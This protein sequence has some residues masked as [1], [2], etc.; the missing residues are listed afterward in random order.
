MHQSEDIVRDSL[1]LT[2]RAA[3]SRSL[4]L[5]ALVFCSTFGCS[6]D[7]PGLDRWQISDP[8]LPES[9][10]AAIAREY[11]QGLTSHD[12]RQRDISAAPCA[13]SSRTWSFADETVEVS[14]VYSFYDMD[15]NCSEGRRSWVGKFSWR[16]DGTLELEFDDH[17]DVWQPGYVES[18]FPRREYIDSVWRVSASQEPVLTNQAMISDHAHQVYTSTTSRV[19]DSEPERYEEMTLRVDQPLGGDAG[20]SGQIDVSRSVGDA[21]SG[22]SWRFECEVEEVGVGDWMII[23]SAD[24]AIDGDQTPGALNHRHKMSGEGQELWYFQ[25]SRPGVLFPLWNNRASDIGGAWF[26][27]RL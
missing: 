1:A 20:C 2:H 19:R 12:W 11:Q 4:L 27:A 6:D 5:G 10:R 15:S 26:D 23:L 16:D 21:L 18:G 22:D 24:P 13:E 17:T 3:K 8:E 14:T 7:L 9:P 25:R